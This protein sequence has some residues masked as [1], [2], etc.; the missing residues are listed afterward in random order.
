[1]HLS[2]SHMH[3]RSLLTRSLTLFSCLSVRTLRYSAW[4]QHGITPEC[5]AA[6]EGLRRASFVLPAEETA[7]FNTF[8]PAPNTSLQ[9]GNSVRQ[10]VVLRTT[11]LNSD[12]PFNPFF[13]RGRF[14][15]SGRTELQ[16]VTESRQRGKVAK[17]FIRSP[18]KRLLTVSRPHSPPLLNGQSG[19]VTD[20]GG[21]GS[22]N[23][24]GSQNGGTASVNKGQLSLLAITKA[25]RTYDKVTSKTPSIPRKAWEQQSDE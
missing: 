6:V 8:L 21:S 16:A 22:C 9:V 13:V 15:Y 3:L 17:I 4:V 7:P 2:V 11:S 24:N 12:L 18:S 20:G 23:E 1:M 5:Q 19:A 14:H 25:T 10:A